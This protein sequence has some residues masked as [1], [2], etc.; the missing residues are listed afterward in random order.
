VLVDDSD[1]F[2]RGAER[3]AAASRALAEEIEIG[4]GE[5]I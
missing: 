2:A 1:Q 4:D 3:L 5:K